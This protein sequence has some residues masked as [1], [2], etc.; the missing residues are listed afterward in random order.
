VL[1]VKNPAVYTTKNPPT[2]MSKYF[3]RVNFRAASTTYLL[4]HMG[5]VPGSE[6]VTLTVAGQVY[7]L[8]RDQDYTIIYE[9]GLLTLMGERAEQA[10]DPANTLRVTFEYLPFFAQMSKT[11]FGTRLNTRWAGSPG[12][13]PR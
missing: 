10:L 12:S 2:N 7:N 6:R 13:G 9:I 5:I 4:G 3:L 11:L 8:V 1:E